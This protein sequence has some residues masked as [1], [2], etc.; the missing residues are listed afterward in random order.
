MED[1]TTRVFVQKTLDKKKRTE[2]RSRR[3]YRM[4]SKSKNTM[5]RCCVLLLLASRVRQNRNPTGAGKRVLGLVN[6]RN[7]GDP[8]YSSESVSPKGL[9]RE[10]R[11]NN[12]SFSFLPVH[13]RR[14]NGNKLY[15]NVSIERPRSRLGE[16]GETQHPPL[17]AERI[18]YIVGLGRR[19]RGIRDIRVD[20][21]FAALALCHI[22]SATR[23]EKS[24][25]DDEGGEGGEDDEDNEDDDDG[26]D[27]E[28]RGMRRKRTLNE[29]HRT[30]NT[31]HTT[32]DNN[33]K[34]GDDSKYQSMFCTLV[35]VP[36]G[37]SEEKD[38]IQSVRKSE[39]A[40]CFSTLRSTRSSFLPDPGTETDRFVSFFVKV[41]SKYDVSSSGRNV[42]LNEKKSRT[43]RHSRIQTELY[44]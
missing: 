2:E 33:K 20:Y 19:P 24:R 25:D 7:A 9:K 32:A 29:E 10:Y 30:H 41:A 35:A 1:E 4:A 31:E 22:A 37:K 27:G 15:L 38:N 44:T 43:E 36:D 14:D 12:L 21:R 13:L 39:E 8:K 11:R 18:H 6:A 17:F 26:N 16:V 34:H 42:R 3:L 28:S 23:S 40:L 5:V